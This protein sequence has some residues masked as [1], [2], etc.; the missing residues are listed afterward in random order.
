MK[1]IIIILFYFLSLFIMPSIFSAIDPA[2]EDATRDIDDPLR[3]HPTSVKPQERLKQTRPEEASELKEEE[4][5][6]DKEK[7]KKVV[8]FF[9]KKIELTGGEAYTAEEFNFLTEKYE[10]REISFEELKILTKEIEREYLKR[11]IIAVCIIPPQDVRD[12][13]VMLQIIESHMGDL[14]IQD[15]KYFKKERIWYYWQ[16]K[17]GDILRY[18]DIYRSLYFVNKN[19]DRQTK[20]ML[21]AGTKPKTTDLRLDVTS[22]FPFHL[23]SSVNKSGTDK[24]LTGFGFRYNNFL[25][26]DDSLIAGRSFK[27]DYDSMYIYHSVPVSSFG[28]SLLYG[29]SYGKSFPK[30]DYTD[31]GVDA[32]GKNLTFQLSQ[33]LFKGS[34]YAGSVN[35]SFDVADK[36]TKTDADGTLVKEKLRT[37]RLGGSYTKK[38]Y[39]YYTTISPEISQGVN[40]FGA[41]RRSELSSRLAPNTFTKFNLSL[42]HKRSMPLGTQLSLG[43]DG[44]L[45]LT[46]LISQEELTVGARGHAGYFAADDGIGVDLEV[47]MP[48]FLI[49]ELIK[50]PFASDS[51]RDTTTTF[52][53]FDYGWGKKRSPYGTELSS[54]DYKGIGAGMR[55]YLY[56]Q[57][58]LKLTWGF[59]LDS[60]PNHSRFYFSMDFEDRMPREIER[61]K[62]LR[63]AKKSAKWAWALLDEEVNRPA[64]PIREKLFYYYALA[65]SAKKEGNLEKALSNFQKVIQLASSLYQQ[66][67]QYT[68]GS[69]SHAE[70]LRQYDRLALR[71]YKKGD[72]NGARDMQEK[73]ITE[74][75]P[76]PLVLLIEF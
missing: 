28:T 26:F 5:I 22:Y 35:C 10:N 38:G 72:F 49:P 29:W 55:I 69:L 4:E 67:Q 25:G 11:G 20:A 8:I 62:E 3:D 42:S 34:D 51:L 66:V 13:T 33:D 12:G 17:P 60:S 48:S 24:A 50:L 21:R 7:E 6:T 16:N 59:P 75:E 43:L 70:E 45:G 18:E 68:K 65:S 46:R 53:F 71:F 37:L 32:R 74:A 40:F 41:R 61:I 19:P 2:L 44:Q 36:K 9:V 27:G 57:A 39:G 54:A 23:T 30:K 47:Q 58:L 64:S 52:A 31:L 63:K 1:K 56:N 73:I 76:K 14:D 15:H